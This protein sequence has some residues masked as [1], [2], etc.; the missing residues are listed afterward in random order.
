MI[1]GG[2]DVRLN[3]ITI[4][5]PVDHYSKSAEVT[6]RTHAPWESPVWTSINVQR[7]TD[8]TPISGWFV[9]S[10]DASTTIT[11]ATAHAV[12]VT[13]SLSLSID[14]S[15]FS[16]LH[17]LVQALSL[18]AEYG[19]TATVTTTTSYSHT[20]GPGPVDEEFRLE[21]QV[22][23]REDSGFYLGYDSS[24]Y[25]GLVDMILKT[26]YSGSKSTAEE[27]DDRHRV[28]SRPYSE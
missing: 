19:Q 27:S 1:I 18:S 26:W 3:T 7:S 24:G 12:S 16:A 4:E 10:P 2:P 25:V 9:R 13:K 28:M 6:V 8:W 14:G 17:P 20:V 15:V 23:W 11:Q 5:D 21:K 22:L